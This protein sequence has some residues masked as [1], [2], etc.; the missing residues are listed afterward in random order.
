MRYSD[1]RSIENTQWGKINVYQPS[2]PANPLCEVFTED[3][4][5][6]EENFLSFYD[7]RFDDNPDKV[8]AYIEMKMF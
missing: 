4:D 2:D 7:G 8:I 6:H 3:P 5:T 1:S